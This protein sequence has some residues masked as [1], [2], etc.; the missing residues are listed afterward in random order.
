MKLK[1]RRELEEDFAFA[2]NNMRETLGQVERHFPK[3][4]SNHLACLNYDLEVLGETHD[5]LRKNYNNRGK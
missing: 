5:Q 1:T 2:V 3:D 4:C